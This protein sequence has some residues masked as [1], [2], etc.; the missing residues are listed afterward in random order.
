[1]QESTVNAQSVTLDI[2]HITEMAADVTSSSTAI[3]TSMH[4]L[5]GG[6]E[7]LVQSA[8]DLKER[9]D[10][11]ADSVNTVTDRLLDTNSVSKKNRTTAE[12]LTALMQKFTVQES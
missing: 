5:A 8:A 12:N 4:T 1:M 11:L 9:F 6:T 10:N 7:H 2:A 3:K